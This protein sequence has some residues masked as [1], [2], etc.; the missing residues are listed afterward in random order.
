[1]SDRASGFEGL[2]L[3]NK[4]GALDAAL[5]QW[6]VRA[7]FLLRPGRRLHPAKAE[8]HTIV[9]LSKPT[10]TGN[11]LYR[12]AIFSQLVYSMCRYMQLTHGLGNRHSLVVASAP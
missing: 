12:C 2:R 8:E 10:I 6:P 3:H 7:S 5:H 1:M 9:I 4:L 11:S